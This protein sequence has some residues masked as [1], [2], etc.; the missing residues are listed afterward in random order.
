MT[1]EIAPFDP[2][3]Y[4]DDAQTQTEYLNA[5]LEDPNPNM[6]LIALKNIARARGMAQVAES[7]NLGRE[8]LYK[9]LTDGAKPR[10]DTILKLI[11]AL[12]LK[13]QAQSIA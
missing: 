2:A 11:H 3:E 9:A 5:A 12:G 8:S 13:L 1:I 10:Y 7:A 6:L 4:L